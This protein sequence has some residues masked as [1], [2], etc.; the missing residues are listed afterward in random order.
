MLYLFAKNGKAYAKVFKDKKTYTNMDAHTASKR[1]YININLED[2]KTHIDI[3]QRSSAFKESDFGGWLFNFNDDIAAFREFYEK[4][5]IPGD[6]RIKESFYKHVDGLIDYDNL[7]VKD[8]AELEFIRKIALKSLS[9]THINAVRAEFHRRAEERR[10]KEKD[11]RIKAFLAAKHCDK[12]D[13]A[14]GSYIQCWVCP[15]NGK[16][17]CYEYE[18]KK[19]REDGVS[20]S[21]KWEIPRFL[22]GR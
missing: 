14:D 1:G 2:Y 5:A 22:L 13:A 20:N 16:C 4:T 6:V 9:E 21:R 17:D 19:R 15:Q 8:D 12:N 10:A 3:L 18:A 7:T 11:A